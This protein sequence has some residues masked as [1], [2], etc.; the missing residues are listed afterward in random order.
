[1]EKIYCIRNFRNIIGYDDYV[2][3]FKEQAI[4]YYKESAIGMLENIFSDFTMTDSHTVYLS[5]EMTKCGQPL[6]FLFEVDDLEGDLR[7]CYC[8]ID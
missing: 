2:R 7:V 6:E 8:G 5:P 1:M 4:D 3:D